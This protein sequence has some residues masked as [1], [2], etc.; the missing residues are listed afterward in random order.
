M[1]RIHIVGR[2]NNILVRLLALL[3]KELLHDIDVVYLDTNRNFSTNSNIQIST[4]LYLFEGH[5]ILPNLLLI[6]LQSMFCGV[7]EVRKLIIISPNITNDNIKQCSKFLVDNG[8]EDARIIDPFV[9]RSWSKLISE[10]PTLKINH[11]SCN[12]KYIEI[13]DRVIVNEIVVNY[14]INSGIRKGDMVSLYRISMDK[15]KDM[16]L[17][18]VNVKAKTLT[19]SFQAP[20]LD[21]NYEI[22]YES[23]GRSGTTQLKN[24]FHMSIPDWIELDLECGKVNV[25]WKIYSFP[26]S[27]NDWIGLFEHGSSNKAYLDH[28]KVSKNQTTATFTL[29]DKVKEGFTL[30]V[31]YFSKYLE[32]FG[33]FRKSKPIRKNF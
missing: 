4:C 21:G 20:I 12:R 26:W 8:V 9:E 6:C 33:T 28:L 27:K 14:R 31:R 3:K 11:S 29:G 24:F 16:L 5:D 19:Y 18:T 30:E 32:R 2:Q 7:S 25:R 10:C 15:Q 13:D 22:R 1:E 23:P 17:E